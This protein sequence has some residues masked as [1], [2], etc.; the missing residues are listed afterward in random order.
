MNP[1]NGP[2]IFGVSAAAAASEAAQKRQREI[3]VKH[4]TLGVA[5]TA[6]TSATGPTRNGN[7]VAFVNG[8]EE[9]HV[10]K[11]MK[12]SL[13][14]FKNDDAYHKQ[15]A[16]ACHA[17]EIDWYSR[18]SGFGGG[19]D[20]F[21]PKGFSGPPFPLGL[22]SVLR[23]TAGKAGLA[24]M[25]LNASI[26]DAFVDATHT[27][28]AGPRDGA[29]KG[30]GA[31]HTDRSVNHINC[32]HDR[33]VVS[34]RNSGAAEGDKSHF[35]CKLMITVDAKSTSVN[36]HKATLGK[37]GAVATESSKM[38]MQPS[39]VL[40]YGNANTTDS[41]T[42]LVLSTP[43]TLRPD[44]QHVHTT[45]AILNVQNQL[46]LTLTEGTV[47]VADVTTEIAMGTKLA[48]IGERI[49]MQNGSTYTL[50]NTLVF[51]VRLDV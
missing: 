29:R 12:E 7:A 46:M 28:G 11:I 51:H 22:R 37:K 1:N 41:V 15:M 5:A 10:Q 4:T 33:G 50:G 44:K 40:Y 25:G 43:R 20:S 6:A 21:P 31:L 42:E 49:I 36:I 34:V 8:S 26:K 32:E 2:P 23:G 9:E 13:A 24:G 38:Q 19:G 47:D 16:A 30:L 39:A 14:S 35:R 45:V 27:S 18:P 3:L 48:N 17:S